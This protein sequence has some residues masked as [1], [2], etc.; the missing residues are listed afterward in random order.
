[1]DSW[2]Q[3]RDILIEVPWAETAVDPF[4]QGILVCNK[5]WGPCAHPFH[6]VMACLG[7]YLS[8]EQNQTEGQR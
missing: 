1:M 6:P 3:P 4:H 2:L 7:L 5:I 8:L